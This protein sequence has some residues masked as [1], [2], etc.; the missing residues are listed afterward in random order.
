[1]IASVAPILIAVVSFFL[2][3]I[4]LG[5]PKGFV[6]DE[7]YYVDGA[8]DLLKYGVE[9]EGSNPEFV[10]HPPIGKWCIALGIRIFGDNEFGWRI[11]AAIA[12]TLII[13]IA[14]R[15]AHELF[16]SPFLTAITAA[17]MAC[18]GLLLVHS[19]TA[20]LDLFL[21]LFV[22]VAAYFWFKQ[23]FWYAGLFFGLALA[24]KWS[25]LYFIVLFGFVSVYRLMSLCARLEFEFY[26]LD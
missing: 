9:V 25:A 4:N 10:V 5:T 1:M 22:L 14:A 26:S 16:K 6:F 12:G 13:L 8:R 23:Q 18:D 3:V 21:T 2:R 7:V 17:L 15:L 19:R 20:L 11:T 24:T